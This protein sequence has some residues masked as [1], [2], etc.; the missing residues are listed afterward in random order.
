MIK[1]SNFKLNIEIVSL[2]FK[3]IENYILNKLNVESFYQKTSFS[4]WNDVIQN[5]HVQIDGPKFPV[6]TTSQVPCMFAVTMTSI[7]EIT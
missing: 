2:L 5:K 6:I 4:F 3:K 1:L 7:N